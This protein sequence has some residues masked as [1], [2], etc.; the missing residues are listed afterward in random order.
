VAE[1]AASHTSA[2]EGEARAERL[3]E[4]TGE[5]CVPWAPDSAM[6]YEHYHRYLWAARLVAGRS[7]LDLGSGEGFGAAILAESAAS[8]V[9][10]DIDPAAV[11][12]AA[13]SYAGPTHPNLAFEQ[14]SATDLSRFAE[15]SFGAAT[16]F[17][18][19]EHVGEQERVLSELKRVLAP[20]GLLI[21]ST[22]DRDVYGEAT[23]QVN[24][25]HER[26][27][28]LAEFRELLAA[29]F[30]HVAI[31]GQRTIAG[32][33][34]SALDPRT[35][36]RGPGSD[37]VVRRSPSGELRLVPEA[38]AVF[39]VALACDGA[40]PPA[41]ASSTLADDRL[42]LLHETARAHAASVAER[43]RL[44]AEV[45]EQLAQVQAH[46]DEQL[47][48]ARRALAEKQQELLAHVRLVSTVEAKLLRTGDELN[49]ARAALASIEASVSW[50]LLQ[51][52]RRA[53]RGAIGDDSRAG[54]AISRL[55]LA[56]GRLL[57]RARGQGG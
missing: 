45:H 7:V 25:Y 36:D 20:D 38:T 1:A 29:R 54:R 43:D 53:L 42:E 24:P 57:P 19:I 13:A 21:V 32:S 50:Q 30:E 37:F 41:G 48:Q 5:R 11:A 28:S 6:L 23:G 2:S 17:E 39:C 15:R 18:T 27:L 33:Y 14:G 35:A 47:E 12:H 34:L 16:V 55:L 26:E 4:W 3:I 31:W 56:I 49:D 46:A 44:L 8:V 51:A 10:L 9:G 22:P 40:L 52:A